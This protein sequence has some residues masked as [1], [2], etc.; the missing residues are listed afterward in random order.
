[1]KATCVW[2]GAA[3]LCAASAP[4]QS[5]SSQKA[6]LEAVIVTA[7]K[8]P[9]KQ[10]QTGKV[11]T[12]ITKEQLQEQQAKTMAQILNEQAGIT[13][14]AAHNTLGSNPSVFM[15][16]APNGRTLILMDGMPVYDPSLISNEFDLNFISPGMVDRVEIARGAQST[17]YGS[18]AIGGVINIITTP[19]N[20]QKPLG[21][22][23]GA[24]YGSFGTF[25]G[26]TNVYG[27]KGRVDYQVRYNKVL[28]EGFS[29]ARDRDNT[30]LFDNDGFNKDALQARVGVQASEAL[31]LSA[32]VNR[33][34]YKADIDAGAFQ[35]DRDFTND[36]RTTMAGLVTEWKQP[37]YQMRLQYMHSIMDRNIVND[38]LHA[39]GFTRYSNDAYKARA[40][41]AEWY[42]NFTLSRHLQLLAGADFRQSSMN[43]DFISISSFGPF[44]S[45]FRDTSL[46]MASG[47]A[48]LL[49]EKKNLNIEAGSRINVHERYGSNATY[50]FNPSYKVNEQWR[51]FGS[52]ASGFKAP[53][54]F[55]L[56][57]SFGNTNLKAEKSLN[58]EA[59]A[60]YTKKQGQAQVVFF[61]RDI[62]DGLDFDNVNFT[63][64]NAAR[65]IV[66]GMELEGSVQLGK[67]IQL[68]G[69]YTLL[70]AEDRVQSRLT[71]KDTSYTYLLRR[72]KH[73][74]NVMLRYQ[75]TSQLTLQ[76]NALY[77][78]ER[79]D[80]GGFRV[81]DVSLDAYTLLN[82]MIQYK[83]T[84][85]IT[86][87]ADG[88]NI[89]NKTFFDLNGFNSM[90]RNLQG[91]LRVQL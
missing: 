31:K 64:F 67:K 25:R 77:V 2:V 73:Q 48:S 6:T 70:G 11:V 44:T 69:N 37:G 13:I 40:H 71:T 80:V 21:A 89:L 7:N 59:G 47:Y 58:Y 20:L 86:L 29:A 17:L 23:L 90:G 46:Y 50:T 33:S 81:A 22:E 35:D 43:N 72:P 36:T 82:C 3:L 8:I 34:V 63:Y 85:N 87:F 26:H 76:V 54:L 74:A 55:Q 27:K 52:L 15:R 68:R 42:G 28:S 57:S 79:L 65:Q 30:G 56:Y 91:G 84:K 62:T 16:G 19:A 75:P 5:D 1:M 45:T 61:H 32:F 60:A 4:A 51:V 24:S 49:Y 88:Q 18:D 10:S 66:W 39:P 78:G 14:N 41:F 38:S 12:V 9:Q 53:T 83:A